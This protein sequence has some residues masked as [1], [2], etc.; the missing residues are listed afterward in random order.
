MA[1]VGLILE[2]SSE[3]TGPDSG[4]QIEVG[5]EIVVSFC[6]FAGFLTELEAELAV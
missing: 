3:A 6:C 5:G 1:K 2:T 4:E